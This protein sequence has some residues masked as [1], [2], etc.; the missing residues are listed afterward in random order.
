MPVLELEIDTTRHKELM[1]PA[2]EF[3]AE[4]KALEE[5]GNLRNEKLA[6]TFKSIMC[7]MAEQIEGGRQR[8]ERIS[9]EIKNDPDMLAEL[10]GILQGMDPKM[11]AALLLKH[12][13]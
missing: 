4:L 13:R 10:L 3:Q 11:F 8:R 1:L 6:Y 2:E 9:D 5:S 7:G 12:N